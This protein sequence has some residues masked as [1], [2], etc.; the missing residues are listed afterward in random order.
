MLFVP[1]GCKSRKKPPL[2][3]TSDIHAA[4]PERNTADYVG[5]QEDK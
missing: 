2:C 5:F 4:Y 1:T 3:V